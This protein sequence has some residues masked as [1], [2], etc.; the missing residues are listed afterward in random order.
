MSAYDHYQPNNQS[1]YA[2][3]SSTVAIRPAFSSINCR[4]HFPLLCKI[5]FIVLQFLNLDINHRLNHAFND[6]HSFTP[7]NEQ[8]LQKNKTFLLISYAQKVYVTAKTN[9][10]LSCG[11]FISNL[12]MSYFKNILTLVSIAISMPNIQPLN[13]R[14][15]SI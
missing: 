15:L 3:A 8:Y 14:I 12:N 13:H 2:P 6:C 11:N 7:V 4:F 10:L 5:Y 1:K 9:P